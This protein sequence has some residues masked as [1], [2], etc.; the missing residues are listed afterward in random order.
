MLKKYSEELYPE[1]F[2]AFPN[3]KM[4]NDGEIDSVILNQADSTFEICQ[5][6]DPIF[7]TE[8]DGKLYNIYTPIEKCGT[9]LFTVSF[10]DNGSR[11]EKAEILF[12]KSDRNNGSNFDPENFENKGERIYNAIGREIEGTI[13]FD[14]S[15]GYYTVKESHTYTYD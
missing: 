7:I 8:I 10:S 1:V 6:F 5:E 14:N 4:I 15:G 3:A 9:Y 11:I 12:E 2:K 13:H